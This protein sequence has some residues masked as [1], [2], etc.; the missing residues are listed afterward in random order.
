MPPAPPKR[1]FASA[2]GRDRAAVH[3]RNPD[4]ITVTIHPPKRY[5][6]SAYGRD[7]AAVHMR[8]GDQF[9]PT[10]HRMRG[11]TGFELHVVGLLPAGMGA[12]ELRA[13]G[14]RVVWHDTA[15]NPGRCDEPCPFDGVTP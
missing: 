13:R 6:A 2:H 1:Y 12:A 4:Q 10:L 8:P 11:V 3:M 5:F 7:R 15:M 9:L 14:A